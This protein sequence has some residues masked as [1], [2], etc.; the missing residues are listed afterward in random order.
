MC[1]VYPG[2]GGG[3]GWSWVQTRPT[4][5]VI[6]QLLVTCSSSYPLSLVLDA[7][8]GSPTASSDSYENPLWKCLQSFQRDQFQT[9]RESKRTSIEASG[10]WSGEINS[11]K[12]STGIKIRQCRSRSKGNR[13]GEKCVRIKKRKICVEGNEFQRH[14]KKCQEWVWERDI[15]F[16]IRN[17]K[18]G[19]QIFDLFTTWWRSFKKKHLRFCIPTCHERWFRRH[20]VMAFSR[21]K[22]TGWMC[23][24]ASSIVLFKDRIQMLTS[25]PSAVG[26][27]Y[28]IRIWW[29]H[30]T[31][32]KTPCFFEWR[33]VRAPEH[34][35]ETRRCWT[36]ILQNGSEWD[37]KSF[38]IWIN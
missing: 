20:T 35:S 15:Q 33:F 22:K 21:K 9:W 24:S 8:K 2:N 10:N 29:H 25:V 28:P 14:L 13:P 4:C 6:S 23:P 36:R 27:L 38:N 16:S 26:D 31:L 32:L 3:R 37:Y 12:A 7:K 30:S 19:L 17:W 11:A 5:S 34:N 18:T 1:D